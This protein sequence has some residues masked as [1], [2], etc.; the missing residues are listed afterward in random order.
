MIEDLS[1]NQEKPHTCCTACTRPWSWCS[2]VWSWRPH[3]PM[4]VS[5]SGVWSLRSAG[6]SQHGTSRRASQAQ[7]ATC[8]VASADRSPTRGLY[9]PFQ[10]L[11]EYPLTYE[12]TS[13]ALYSTHRVRTD[14]PRSADYPPPRC[15]DWDIRGSSSSSSKYLLPKRSVPIKVPALVSPAGR[16]CRGRPPPLVV[17]SHSLPP[18]LCR[19]FHTDVLRAR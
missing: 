2:W 14:T 1:Y 6:L 12:S 11:P 4:T 5:D 17:A 10:K 15:G 9:R 19:I 7:F 13:F 3:P 8:V 18:M 16:Q